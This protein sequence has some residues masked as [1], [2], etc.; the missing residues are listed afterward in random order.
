MDVDQLAAKIISECPQLVRPAWLPVKAQ[1]CS[2]R[3][4][5]S[6]I[7]GCNP[8]RRKNFQWPKCNG[9]SQHKSFLLQLELRTLP[10]S[11]RALW[12]GMQSGLFQVF[13]CFHCYPPRCFDGME[14]IPE[15]D[16]IPSLKTLASIKLVEAG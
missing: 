1:H 12:G 10:A 5:A 7:G 6:K 15:S 13:Y 11:A 14:L 8:F 16:M 3:L 4:Q 2:G 9:C